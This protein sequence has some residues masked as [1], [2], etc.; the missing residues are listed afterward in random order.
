ME[1]SLEEA[2]SIHAQPFDSPA[3][4]APIIEAIGDAKIVMLGEA[5]H[6]TSEFYTIR[7][8]LSKR[9]IREKGFTL[10]AVEGDWPSSQ[11]VN[12][13]IKGYG[14]GGKTAREVLQA[15]TRWPTWMWANEEIAAFIDWLKLHNEKSET[16]TGFYG[17]DI[18]SLWESMDEVVHYL[19]HTNPAGADLELAKKAFSCF[20]PFN[21][22][23]EGYAISSANFSTVCVD[24]VSKLLAS[25]R[26]NEEHYRDEQECGLNL[27]INALVTKNAEDYYRAMVKSGEISWNIRDEHMVEAINEVRDYHGQDAKIIIWEHNT[28]IGDAR[29]TDMR[30]DGM[31]NV[32]QVLREQNRPED[33]F[34]V[35]FGTYEGTVIASQAWGVPYEVMAVP[36]ARVN[37][38]EEILHR[39]GPHDKYLLFDSGNFTSFDRWTGH[40]AIGVVYNPEHEAHGNYVPSRIASRYDAFVFIDRTKALVPLEVKSSIL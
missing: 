9:L 1:Q 30:N 19:A 16:K 35:G 28:H 31:L 22:E 34:A 15:F 17:I 14:H 39:T 27:E 8:E 29:A 32:G 3:D 4:L 12:R 18:Y 7:A 38:W 20:E 40:R 5:S 37:S 13:F 23:P 25:I 6:G 2:V 24:E 36:P 10:I 21:R 33:V 11:Q 26:A